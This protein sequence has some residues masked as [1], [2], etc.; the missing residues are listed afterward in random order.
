[1]VILKALGK[2]GMPYIC[3]DKFFNHPADFESVT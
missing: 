1:M 3:K 2:N